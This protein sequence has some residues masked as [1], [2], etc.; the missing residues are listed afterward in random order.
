MKKI[1]ATNNSR[2]G[3]NGI[4]VIL[5]ILFIS[6]VVGLMAIAVD[7]G[8]YSV[9]KLRLQNSSNAAALAALSNWARTSSN[10]V[11]RTNAQRASDALAAANGILDKVK[12]FSVAAAPSGLTLASSG[13]NT[14]G[15]GV[16]ELGQWITSPPVGCTAQTLCC[17]TTYPCF[18]P[19]ASADDKVTAARIKAK[20]L[21]SSRFVASFFNAIKKFD[22]DWVYGGQTSSDLAISS[23]STSA[24]IERCTAFILDASRSTVA[25]THNFAAPFPEVLNGAAPPFPYTLIQTPING[26]LFAYHAAAIGEP[27]SVDCSSSQNSLEKMYWCNLGV[28]GNYTM[29]NYIATRNQSAMGPI[30]GSDTNEEVANPVDTG[31]RDTGGHYLSDYRIAD[32]RIGKYWIDFYT[33]AEPLRTFLLAMNASLR[34]LKEV[35]SANDKAVFIVFG[36]GIRDR[37]PADNGPGSRM[38]NNLDYLIQLTN[39]ENR[40]TILPDGSGWVPGQAPIHPN[41]VDRGWFPVYDGVDGSNLMQAFDEAYRTLTSDCSPQS[42]KSIIIA[43]DGVVTADFNRTTRVGRLI[44]RDA[45]DGNVGGTSGAPGSYLDAV[46]RLTSTTRSATDPN[47][48]GLLGDLIAAKIAVTFLLA[49]DHVGPNYLNIPHP[50]TGW[51]CAGQ[52]APCTPG[53]P[54]GNGNNSRADRYLTPS[55]AASLGYSGSGWPNIFVDLGSYNWRRYGSRDSNGN[56]IDRTWSPFV[57]SIMSNCLAEGNAQ[58][59]LGQCAWRYAGQYSGIIFRRPSG[60]VADMVMKSGGVFCPIMPP[61]NNPQYWCTLYVDAAG[62]PPSSCTVSGRDL[63]LDPDAEVRVLDPV[64]AN[65]DYTQ[66]NARELTTTGAYAAGCARA[67]IGLNPFYLVTEDP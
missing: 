14:A 5:L 53:V 34:D 57:D 30:R 66:A 25:T 38:T 10:G 44:P 52:P 65:R 40:G 4:S 29:V 51:G 9:N 37:V 23:Q 39:F 8:L 7:L 1:P 24:V 27:P 64:H 19:N 45:Y 67:A 11:V 13:P 12:L 28:R 2:R 49:G 50:N 17:P 59:A 58:D 63:T 26:G 3:E 41:F 33:K 42:K 6:I 21:D 48:S 22:G 35:S 15:S 43:S 61:Y 56:F 55:E 36:T 54:P 20:T 47:S 46:S 62:N 31:L 18:I 60:L 16:L 32:T